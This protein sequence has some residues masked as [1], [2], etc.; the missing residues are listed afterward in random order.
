MSA[1]GVQDTLAGQVL[2]VNAAGEGVGEVEY[3]IIQTG[4]GTQTVHSSRP[5]LVV[6]IDSP[7]AGRYVVTILGLPD[8]R[9]HMAAI[10]RGTA[11][12]AICASA[13]I[14]ETTGF[15]STVA[16]LVVDAAGAAVALT[17]GDRINGVV[18]WARSNVGLP[19]WAS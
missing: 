11:S 13:D 7:V 14:V 12:A 1:P 15:L 8:N 10:Q 17:P 16:A 9:K 6:G 2:S 18:R 3:T 19:L 5:D 4:V